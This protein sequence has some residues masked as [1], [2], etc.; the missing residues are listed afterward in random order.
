[1]DYATAQKTFAKLVREKMGKG[2]TPGEN[3]T[4]YQ[5]DDKEARSTGILPQLLNPI[6]EAEAQSLLADPSW[7]AQEKLDGKRVLLQRRDDQIIGINRK[8]L[9]IALPQ[10][11]VQH[12]LTIG[13][14]CW[15]LDGEAMGD[16]FFAFDVLESACVDLRQQPYRERLKVLADLVGLVEGLPICRIATATTTASKRRLLAELRWR[17]AE[18]IVFK[19]SEAPYIPGRPASGGDQRKL[20]FTATASCLVTGA[21]GI[22][23]SVALHLLDGQARVEVGSVTIPPGQEIPAAGQI[24]EVRYLYAY[25]GGSLFQPVYLGRRDDLTATD[26]VLAQLKFKAEEDA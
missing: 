9:T 21:N 26:C 15:L 7:Y 25:P 1:M 17:H 10:G 5:G 2:Y 16:S 11:I 6:G 14:Q 20:K 13:S 12:A 24:V 22:K 8:G 18:G 19:R 4:P 3:G 23:R